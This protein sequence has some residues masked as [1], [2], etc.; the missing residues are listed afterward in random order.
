MILRQVLDNGIRVVAERIPSVKSVS[1]GLWVNVGSRD[2]AE[3][4]YG[5]SHFLE[6]MFFKGTK[7]RT[8]K[9]IALT[10]DELGGELNAFTTRE[11]TTF[12]A[13]VL[14]EH[15]STVIDLLSDIF[16]CSLFDPVEIE[17]ES[18]V[19]LEEIKMV[20]DDPEDLV[21]D[22]HLEET[23]KGS[24]LAHSILGTPEHVSSMTREKI[25]SYIKRTYDPKEMVIAIAGHFDPK[26][27]MAQITS[28]LGAYTNTET[29][30]EKRR[31]ASIVP[32]LRV[33][34]RKL[35]QTHL[36]IT[37]E[38][39]S[40]L[41]PKRYALYLLNTILG[42]GASS[43]LFQEVRE[44]R[45]WA[46]SIYSAPASY[47]DCGL[48]TVYAGTSPQNAPK[49]VDV[50]L[51]MLNKVKK[52]GVDADELQRAKNQTKGSM[53][54]SM[55]STSTRMCRIAKEEL[56]FAQSFSLKEIVSEIDKVTLRDLQDLAN[57]L[58]RQETLS[59]TALGQVERSAL[60]EGLRI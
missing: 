27:M 34:Q 59:L 35:E 28:A 33:K 31:A 7:T 18:Q 21:Y 1:I 44:E 22:L 19:I 36:C 42:G 53:M 55:E 10:A 9:Q 56:Y 2:E 47:F 32:H 5:T 24:A 46:Y 16:Q 52:D 39:L 30:L 26:Q 15:L 12:Y 17:K 37:T 40:Y 29:H 23:W 41:S 11:S 6:H 8:A 60:S 54:L 20:E 50:V 38:G 13:K 45:G 4:E 25:L 48:F 14:D 49:V 58:F 3:D 51:K 43:R 57:T